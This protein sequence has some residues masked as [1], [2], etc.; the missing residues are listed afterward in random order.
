M[1][2]ANSVPLLQRPRIRDISSDRFALVKTSGMAAFARLLDRQFNVSNNTMRY[3]IQLRYI[4]GWDDAG[5]TEEINGIEE[6]M[7]FETIEQ[8]QAA[9]EEFFAEITIAVAAGDMDMEENPDDY[10]IVDAD[11]QSSKNALAIIILH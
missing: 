3:K 9:L 2:S 6:P 4:Y 5:W 10:R 11:R 8:A 7:R 1:A